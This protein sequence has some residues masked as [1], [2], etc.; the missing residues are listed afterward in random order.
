[1]YLKVRNL[2]FQIPAAGRSDLRNCR[3][4]SQKFKVRIAYAIDAA[5][6][7]S[8]MGDLMGTGIVPERK[9]KKSILET[10]DLRPATIIEYFDLMRPIYRK[11]SAYGHFG[12]G[13]PEFILKKTDVAESL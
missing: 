4:L 8:V 7:V 9:V 5:E 11:T 13:E 2:F 1:M 3:G 12:R 6:P 10:F